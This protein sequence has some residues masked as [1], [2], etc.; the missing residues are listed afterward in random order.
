MQAILDE[1]TDGQMLQILDELLNFPEGFWSMSQ[2]IMEHFYWVFAFLI[3]TLQFCS[4]TIF[5]LIHRLT[6]A[7]IEEFR[8]IFKWQDF[9]YYTT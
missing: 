6:D 4:E 2:G 3:V 8:G 1:G 9:H 5:N 7:E